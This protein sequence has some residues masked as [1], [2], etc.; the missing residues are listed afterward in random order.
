[1]YNLNKLS[2]CLLLGGFFSLISCADT[3][4]TQKETK[5]YCLDEFM[6]EKVTLYTALSAPVTETLDLTGTVEYNPDNVINFVSLVG[7]VVTNT[8]FS[9][10]DNVKNGQL[11]A[12]ISSTELSG[13]LSQKR[14]LL[15]Q[16]Q[17]AQRALESTQSLYR[18]KIASQKD[19]IIAKS[20]L[21]V[22]T[23]ELENI[24]A[25]L[26]LYS[27]SDERGVF[28]IRAPSSGIIV[29]KNIAPGMQISAE[30]D[31]LFTV[32]DLNEVWIMANVYSGNVAYIKENMNVTIKALA[33]P[34]EKLN[35]KVNALSQ[36][37]DSDE[38]VL[39]ARIVMDNSTRKL[40]PGMQ[41]DVLVEK[42]L[43]SSAI[44]VPSN[45]VIFD[46]NQH[47]LLIYKNACAIEVRTVVPFMH[48]SSQVF[49][50]NNLEEGEKIITKN[51]LL[52]YNHLKNLK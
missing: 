34:K 46:N 26:N 52:I 28:Q 6:K 48:N 18:D 27:A 51:H 40:I 8:Y 9:L 45:A 49:F 38:P 32:S 2:L 31:P 3:L 25:Q 15:S 50:E 16:L 35:G 13:L 39:K 10:G 24:D 29:N 33:Y 23:A 4:E 14:S 20:D 36:V 5:G 30:S 11:L 42:E 41:V 7:G 19:L 47:F 21:E 12:E 22:L 1:M 17:V 44:A 37:F 43:G